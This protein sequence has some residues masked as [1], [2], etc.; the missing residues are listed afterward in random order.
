MLIWGG[1]GSLRKGFTLVELL[2]VIAIIG[3]LIGLLL[4][5]V[6][7]AREAARR[8][9]CTNHLKQITLAC[10]NYHDVHN[11][12]PAGRAGWYFLN[13]RMGYALPLLPFVE[14]Q[15]RYDAFVA[16]GEYGR[17]NGVIGAGDPGF[18]QAYRNDAGSLAVTRAVLEAD[19]Q[20]MPGFICP[21][22]GNANKVFTVLSH[23]TSVGSA[24]IDTAMTNLG[25]DL[26]TSCNSYCASMGDALAG[27]NS[28]KDNSWQEP[29]WAGTSNNNDTAI[30][31]HG[32]TL[33][34]GGTA[35]SVSR[36]E[37]ACS[38]GLF[39]PEMWHTFSTVTD[40]TSNTIAFSEL[41][42]GS[43][44]GNYLNNRPIA[45]K[46][47]VHNTGNL[48]TA[49]TTLNPSICL[50]EAPSTAD[51]KLLANPGVC[52]RG[53]LWYGG[54]SCDSRFNTVL[55]PNSP[56]CNALAAA[57]PSGG[58]YS[59]SAWGVFSAQ[60]NHPGGVNC[61]LADGSVRFISDSVDCTN[62][63]TVYEADG[64]TPTT[65]ASAHKMVTSGQSPYGIWGAMGTPAGG[66]SK[67][68]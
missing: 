22:D 56:S 45:V 9:K 41:L 23:S 65:V 5:A 38:R 19:R 12:F 29:G 25:E 49:A 1:G 35:L 10:H 40:G 27:N 37:S 51:R 64:T 54:Y 4:P 36:I 48:G 42:V 18:I 8:M 61:S 68:L 60:S 47:G 3:I 53:L 44:T 33:S 2:V 32:D 28:M 50:T 30:Y 11:A 16:Y 34:G 26:Q 21:S 15:Q 39:M 20:P 6:Q 62:G 7:A 52:L 17:T 63:V 24:G 43:P 67:S 55:P 31:S 46:G 66:E 59:D 13:A 58:L 57:V 14:Q